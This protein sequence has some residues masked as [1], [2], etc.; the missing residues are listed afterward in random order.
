MKMAQELLKD[1]PP[2]VAQKALAHFNE[3]FDKQ[4]FTDTSFMPWVKRADDL[5]F[6]T[7]HP[8]LNRSGALSNCLQIIEQNIKRIEIATD[9]KIPY[10]AIHNNGGTIRVKVTPKMR[11]YFWFI[12]RSLTKG[13]AHGADPPEHIA[14]WKWMALTKKEYMTIRIPQ[15]QFIGRSEQLLKDIDKLAIQHILN[16]FKNLSNGQ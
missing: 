8:L 4:G 16:T 12:Y 11:R 14:K 15:R 13:Y 9:S 10:A 5:T 3:S 2:L 1:L 7:N 6:G